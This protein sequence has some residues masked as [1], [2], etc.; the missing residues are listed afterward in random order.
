MPAV[1]STLLAT[2]KAVNPKTPLLGQEVL[3]I[4]ANINNFISVLNV[5]ESPNFLRLRGNRGRG[6]GVTS[7]F[8]REVEIWPYRAW[9]MNN[10]Q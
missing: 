9:A 7:D 3:K 4:H 1:T 10:M 8:R 2:V 5:C 6:T